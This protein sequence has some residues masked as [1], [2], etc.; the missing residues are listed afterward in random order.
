MQ[1]GQERP[2]AQE[3]EAAVV[4]KSERQLGTPARFNIGTEV[5][6]KLSSMV[7]DLEDIPLDDWAGTI[8]QSP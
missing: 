5:R 7:P 8:Q 3:Q 4:R 2:A 1:D 6:V